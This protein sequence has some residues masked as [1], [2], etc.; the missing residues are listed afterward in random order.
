MAAPAAHRTTLS[1]DRIAWKPLF[2]LASAELCLYLL[3]SGP[4]AYGYTFETT[5]SYLRILLV[6]AALNGVAAVATGFLPKYSE[7]DAHA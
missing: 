5:G 6:C 3:S 1:R 4:L 7:F 2:A